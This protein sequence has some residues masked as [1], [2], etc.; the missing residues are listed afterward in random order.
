MAQA[1]SRHPLTQNARVRFQSSVCGIF[2]DK[3]AVEFVF[4]RILW[5]YPVD[6]IPP[7]FR[8]LSAIHNPHHV[9]VIL[10]TASLSNAEK[11]ICKR[12]VGA[13]LSGSY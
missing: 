6:I 13:N 12:F 11:D 2:G 10:A 8:A 5:L 1:V 7:P 4:P 9:K 3:E